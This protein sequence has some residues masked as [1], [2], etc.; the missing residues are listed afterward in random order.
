[1]A[2][3]RDLRTTRP[4]CISK[5]RKL[6]ARTRDGGACIVCGSTE[7]LVA[8]HVIPWSEGGSSSLDN[9]QTL[10]TAHN[11]DKITRGQV[12]WAE[13]IGRCRNVG[14]DVIAELLRREAI[15]RVTEGRCINQDEAL[16]AVREDF[17]SRR[18]RISEMIARS[19]LP[20]R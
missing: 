17:D 7:Q 8:D 9:L 12:E 18:Q 6:A 10:C 5:A 13:Y 2:R 20:P 15:A 16:A 1:M 14:P 19:S 11:K 3:E 4:R